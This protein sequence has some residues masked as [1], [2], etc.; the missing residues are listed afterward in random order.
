V[1]RRPRQDGLFEPNLF[2]QFFLAGQP[3]RRL[4]E[5]AIRDSCLS[6]SEY[7]VFSAIEELEPVT[8]AD[9]ARVIG[10]P[11]PTLTTQLDHLLRLGLVRRQPNRQDKRSYTLR[12]TAHGGRVKADA[13]RALL[14]ATRSLDTELG[15]ESAEMTAMLGRLRTAAEAAL[16]SG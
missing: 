14:A 12:L 9:V 4:I 11:R 6:A 1:P 10:A 15:G 7:A 16:E 3:I 13:G 5:Q 8:P 2:L